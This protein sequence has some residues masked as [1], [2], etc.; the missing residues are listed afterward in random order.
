MGY[1][2]MVKL[3]EEIDRTLYN[4]VWQQVRRPAPW[5]VAG[6]SWQERALA[7]MAKEAAE[8]AADPVKAEEVRRA[9][10]VCKCKSVSLGVIED[11]IRAH[12]LTDVAGVKE[13]TNASGGCGACAIRIDEIL[14]QG[15]DVVEPTQLNVAAE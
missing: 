1:I 14:E 4:P 11:A 10:L 7:E 9:K 15:I 12:V 3:V 2:G 5:A 6:D 13:K 8:L